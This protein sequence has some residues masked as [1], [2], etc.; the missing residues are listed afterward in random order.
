VTEPRTPDRHVLRMLRILAERRIDTN[1][2]DTEVE[3]ARA[4]AMRAAALRIPHLYAEAEPEHPD[5]LAWIEEVLAATTSGPSGM[6]RITTGPT[7]YLVG[8]TGRGKTHQAYGAIRRLVASGCGMGWTA[9]NAVDMQGL[10]RVRDGHDTEGALLR[11]M[12]SP[13]LLLD[14]LGAAA[15]VTPWSDDV[16][17]RLVTHRYERRMPTI[18]TSNLKPS[19]LSRQLGDRVASRLTEMT[20]RVL[21]SGPD[22]RRLK[23]DRQHGDER[24]DAA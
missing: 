23:N 8:F 11:L 6:R 14:D 1:A 3:D 20:V 21:I 10:T 2:A 15:K 17:Y 5:V 7:L 12:R 19:D 24:H 4:E 9:I 22:R 13:L 16:L 18:V